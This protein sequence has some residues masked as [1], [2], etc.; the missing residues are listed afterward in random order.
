MNI[1]KASL[2]YYG[3]DR[4]IIVELPDGEIALF[5]GW[6]FLH[7]LLDGERAEADAISIQLSGGAVAHFS[8]NTYMGALRAGEWYRD[9][10][11]HIL[12][13]GKLPYRRIILVDDDD[14][15][16]IFSRKTLRSGLRR[17]EDQVENGMTLELP[18]GTQAV[19]SQEEYQ[20]GLDA[21]QHYQQ[22][23]DAA[24]TRRKA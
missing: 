6:L 12:K 19:L 15:A 8:H 14:R 4:T 10:T 18:D 22:L 17:Y 20:A 21:A 23:I 9:H 16:A 3:R 24:D 5:P 13:M 2:W 11:R 1:I 7:G